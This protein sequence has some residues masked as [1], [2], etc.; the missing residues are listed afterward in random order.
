MT[1]NTETVEKT[2]GVEQAAQQV[3]QKA[4]VEATPEKNPLEREIEF[5]VKRAD[6]E[7]SM[8]TIIRNRAKTAKFNG[9][10]KGKAPMGMVMAAYGMEAE[11]EAFNRVTNVAVSK[12]IQDY[13]EDIVSRPSVDF[14]NRDGSDA[15]D[16]ELKL[17]AIFEVAP[18]VVIPDLKT[19][20]VTKFEC[21]MGDEDLNRTI[22]VM[23]KQRAVYN[24]VSRAC[25]DED[26]V[27]IDFEGKLGDVVFEG[28][29]AN[30]YSFVLGQ[31]QM[32]PDFEANVK[33]MSAGEEKTFQMTFP[34]N[35][36]AK[37]MAGKEV[38]FTVKLKAVAEPK[39]PELDD[40]FARSL[41]V[42]EGGIEKLKADVRDNLN[43]EVNRRLEQRTKQNVMTALL[44]AANFPVPKTIV[45]QERNR[46]VQNNV[47]TLKAQGITIPDAMLTDQLMLPQATDSVRLSYLMREIIEQQKIT[48]TQEEIRKVAED[49]AKSYEDPSE[50]V[51]W[52]MNN[53]E[54]KDELT[55]VV[56]ES[57]VVKYILDNADTK[58]EAIKFETL[59]AGR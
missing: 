40:D 29:K 22:S 27:T 35:Y 14:V 18:K 57:N 19:I 16:P 56:R 5:S 59:M 43:R 23:Q 44:K 48:A 3:E 10:R 4:A 46:M 38:S 25:K 50:V 52:Y 54:R 24:E 8:M 21:T 32:L 31:G 28:G 12:L 55:A 45:E 20:K 37:E 34:E 53:K 17:K 9:F 30:D 41:G 11:Q 13:S 49:I 58:T 36:G 51:D 39:Y 15:N 1:D 33:G 47:N 6:I 7:K 26:K 42:N 2:E